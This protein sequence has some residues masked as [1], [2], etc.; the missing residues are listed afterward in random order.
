MELWKRVEER[1]EKW[2]RIWKAK[3]LYTCGQIVVI[4]CVLGNM[5]CERIDIVDKR[6]VNRQLTIFRLF[7]NKLKLAMK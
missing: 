5:L 3:H 6:G 2:V 1:L 7:F 4:N